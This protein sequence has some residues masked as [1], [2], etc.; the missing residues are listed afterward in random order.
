[1]SK[2]DRIIPVSFL[3]VV[4]QLSLAVA[5]FCHTL[6]KRHQRLAMKQKTRAQLKNLTPEQLDDIGI[7][8]AQAQVEMNKGFGE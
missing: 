8:R 2:I 4:Q 5:A 1:M 6:I 7:T 3:Y